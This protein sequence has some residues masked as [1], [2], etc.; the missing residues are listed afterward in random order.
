ME[1]YTTIAF[2]S[3]VVFQVVLPISVL[4]WIKI[5]VRKSRNNQYKRVT[6]SS[7]IGKGYV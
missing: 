1:I 2:I 5:Q 4:V 3:T 7:N 6:L